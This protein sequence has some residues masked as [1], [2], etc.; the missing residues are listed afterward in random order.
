VLSFFVPGSLS[1]HC[2]ARQ[3]GVRASCVSA[4]FRSAMVASGDSL[5]CRIVAVWFG[6]VRLGEGCLFAG[7]C[8]RDRGLFGARCFQC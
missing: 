8:W 4:L 1:R 7:V 3:V 2:V 5:L 6:F